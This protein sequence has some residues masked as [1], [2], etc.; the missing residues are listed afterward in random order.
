MDVI[1]SLPSE[2]DWPRIVAE[3]CEDFCVLL[4]RK[5]RTKIAEGAEQTATLRGVDEAFD[6]VF[7]EVERLRAG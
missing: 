4:P 2:S 3:T 1:P 7:S 6:Y 5:E